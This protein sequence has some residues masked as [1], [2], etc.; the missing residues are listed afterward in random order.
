MKKEICANVCGCKLVSGV[1][2]PRDYPKF[3]FLPNSDEPDRVEYCRFG[4]RSSVCDNI[5]RGYGGKQMKIGMESCEEACDNFCNGD[6]SMA[7][8]AAE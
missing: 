5:S 7:S 8:N 4:C 3:N 6:V 2:C 1:K